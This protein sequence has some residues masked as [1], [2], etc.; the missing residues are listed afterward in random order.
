MPITVNVSEISPESLKTI[1]EMY[2][3]N[4]T[5]GE[6][7]YLPRAEGGFQVVIKDMDYKNLDPNDC[8]RQLRWH[9]RQLIP[10]NYIPLLKE[11]E[12]LLY[13]V[14][15]CVLGVNVVSY[16]DHNNKSKQNVETFLRERNMKSI[17]QNN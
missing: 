3:N 12:M 6:I 17:E 1:I 8:I 14:M 9:R 13:E 10:Q 15:R 16:I 2:N 4:Q 11:E 7:E 5:L